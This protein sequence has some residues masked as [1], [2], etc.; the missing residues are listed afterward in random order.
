MADLNLR[1]ANM[2]NNPAVLARYEA[3]GAQIATLDAEFQAMKDKLEAD[4]EALERRSVGW[5]E[6]VT[7]VAYKLD[8]MFSEYMKEL[9]YKGEV[10]LVK[11]GRF[12]EYQIQMRVSFR[13]NEMVTD[14]TGQ[15]QSGGERTVS[16]VM[17]LMGK[18]P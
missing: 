3:L 12:D 2:V 9:K 15:R 7:N 18:Q 10:K 17:Y 6:A 16:T 8:A 5:V 11:T 1:I 4:A 14:L 13:E